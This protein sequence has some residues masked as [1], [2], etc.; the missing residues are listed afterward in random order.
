[1]FNVLVTGCLLRVAQGITILRFELAQNKVTSVWTCYIPTSPTEQ[2]ESSGVL[3]VLADT[4]S[5]QEDVLTGGNRHP[6]H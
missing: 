4:V 2:L 5:F 1:M 6:H 3:G